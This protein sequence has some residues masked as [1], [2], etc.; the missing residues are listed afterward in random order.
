M[1]CASCNMVVPTKEK[2]KPG[3]AT[4]LFAALLCVVGMWPLCLVPFCCKD[5][6]DQLFLCTQCGKVLQNEEFLC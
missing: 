6:Q 1:G 5:C 3:H 2:R 4:F